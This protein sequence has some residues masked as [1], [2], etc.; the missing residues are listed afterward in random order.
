MK[1]FLSL[2]LIYILFMMLNAAGSAAQSEISYVVSFPEAQAHY[3]D[4]EMNIKGI[5]SSSIDVRMP[6]WAP[7]SYLVREFAKNV[8]G[9]SARTPSNTSLLSSK[10]N[11]NTWRISGISTKDITISYRVYAF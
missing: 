9:F 10:I 6:V 7:G 1:K 4:V 5:K 2:T 3:A 11:K 8:E